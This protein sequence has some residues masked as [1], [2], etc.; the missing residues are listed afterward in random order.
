MD[1][2]EDNGVECKR[3][4]IDKELVLEAERTLEEEEDVRGLISTVER[5]NSGG[6]V[7]FGVVTGRQHYALF[8]VTWQ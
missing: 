7:H 4:L 3:G 8:H 1:E 2:R 6:V 5:K